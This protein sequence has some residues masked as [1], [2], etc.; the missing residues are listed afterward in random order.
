MGQLSHIPERE[1]EKF[2]GKKFVVT[3][4]KKM[5]H[6]KEQIKGPEKNT[7]KQRKR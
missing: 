2:I 7:T 3:K 4:Q 6:M 1:H 5:A